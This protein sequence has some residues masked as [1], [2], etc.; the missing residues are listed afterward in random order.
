MLGCAWQ[1]AWQRAVT[2]DSKMA[3]KACETMQG[4]PAG[5]GPHAGQSLVYRRKEGLAVRLFYVCRL[6]DT[7]MLCRLASAE[8]DTGW[9]VTLAGQPGLVA[10][11]EARCPPHDDG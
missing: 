7:Q 10:Q 4:K 3:C 2:G 1:R 6:C 9:S 5:T 11:P 8:H